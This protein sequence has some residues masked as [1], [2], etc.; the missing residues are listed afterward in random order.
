[1]ISTFDKLSINPSEGYHILEFAPGVECIPLPTQTLPPATHTNCYVLGVP[2]GERVIIDPAAKSKDAL[3]ILSKKI[4]EIR[5]T[6][7]VIIATILLINTKIIL[8][9]WKKLTKLYKAPIW[10]SKETSRGYLKTRK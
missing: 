6:G 4:D 1:L 5:A 8:E 2:G 3:D 10:A 7:S 9:I